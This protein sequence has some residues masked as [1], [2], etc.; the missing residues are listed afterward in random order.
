M[1]FTTRCTCTSWD[2]FK[3]SKAYVHTTSVEKAPSSQSK[4]DVQM[5][6]CPLTLYVD[7]VHHC[8]R[9]RSL[10]T[11]ISNDF[12]KTL[13]IRFLSASI[14]PR[15][16]QGTYYT[17]HLALKRTTGICHAHYLLPY[18]RCMCC[19]A[20]LSYA[21]QSGSDG[22]TPNALPAVGRISLKSTS[23][24][25]CRVCRSRTF[26]FHARSASEASDVSTGRFIWL[27]R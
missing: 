3:L 16:A 26:S 5:Q 9:S 24:V 21:A 25:L 20:F 10:L 19:K 6:R 13:C 15:N 17:Q 11:A 12:R 8:T 23:T 4:I 14:Y 1:T 2:L 7:Q 27:R 22:L 18:S